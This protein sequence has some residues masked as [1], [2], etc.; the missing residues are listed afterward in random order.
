MAWKIS[1]DHFDKEA[2][3]IYGPSSISD[4]DLAYLKSGKGYQFEM[5][6][7]DGG[8]ML[9]GKSTDNDSDAAFG[10]LDD[11]GEPAYGCTTIAY[12]QLGGAY[13]RL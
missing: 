12:R 7:D 10:P 8:L 2:V 1:Y 11:Y 5:R 3:N 9:S 4:K 6:D 13:E